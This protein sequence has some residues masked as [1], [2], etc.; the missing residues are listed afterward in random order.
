M[1]MKFISILLSALLLAVSASTASAQNY[2]VC[3]NGD[4]NNSGRSETS[5]FRSY[6]KAM[7]TF[8]IM[9]AG[10]NILFCRGGKFEIT[11]RKWIANYSCSA[12]KPCAI[13]SYGDESLDRPMLISN[14]ETAINF[15]NSGSSKPDGGYIVRDLVL[16]STANS[17]SG[18]AMYND[19]NDVLIENVHIEGF[20]IGVHAAGANQ[21]EQG[22]NQ[23]N[24]KLIL[25]NSTVLNNSLQG[26]L[27]GCNDCLIE[28]NHF[29]NNGFKAPILYHNIYISSP[30]KSQNFK[31]SNMKVRNNTIKYSTRID[32]VCQG[33]SLVVHGI[34]R[35]L[36]IV[37]NSIIEDKG[38]AGS[39]CWG[40]AVDPGNNL[41]ESFIG[42]TIMRNS[43]RNVGGLG[44][45]C[46]SCKDV[47]IADNTIIDESDV[48][49]NAIVVP[50]K[51]EDNLKSENVTIRNNKIINNHQ[52]GVGIM[53]GGQ[54]RFSATGNE[55]SLSS[56]DSRA[57]CIRGIDAN[58]KTDVSKNACNSHT[59]ITIIDEMAP[60]DEIPVAENTQPEV[61]SEEPELDTTTLYSRPVV[62]VS[63][64][65]SNENTTDS[66]TTS[67]ITSTDRLTALD[68][69]SEEIASSSISA[70]S[71][72][73]SGTSST[74]TAD[75]MLED[76]MT[77]STSR[78]AALSASVQDFAS[79][80]DQPTSPD[81][82]EPLASEPVSTIRDSESTSSNQA[83]SVTVG[84]VANVIENDIPV[85]ESQCRVF[86]RGRCMM[87]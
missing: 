70:T 21:P 83:R 26:W 58:L 9:S 80:I 32:G 43:V 12:E 73:S 33:A 76:E 87:R 14:G 4:D 86:A 44:I 18:I 16:I 7:D 78:N 50:N 66:E 20:N 42:L 1:I 39:A 54:N 47:L 22:S 10:D 68:T 23:A 41:D 62:S 77:D 28:N 61:I 67:N 56:T 48:I 79:M 2:Y 29:E 82:S 65:I 71:G 36:E 81:L 5:P 25:R 35:N 72:S 13:Q 15:Q 8:G 51:P 59:S 52:L 6:E 17:N 60:S 3:D 30:I 37:D 74:G 75:S 34:I 84:E 63:D 46:A 19:V 85:E 40:I 45:G 55:I 27:G 64:V 53:L 38:K 31:I 11:E 57:T 69:T 49:R 24:D